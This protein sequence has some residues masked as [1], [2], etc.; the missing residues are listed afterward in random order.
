MNKIYGI[1]AIFA[2]AG[3]LIPTSAMQIEAASD[4]DY[5]LT[6]AEKGKKYIK[7]K[8]NEMQNSNIQDWKNQKAVLEIYD[9]SSNEIE[10]LEEAIENGDVKPA[11]KLF[12]SSMS[13]IK[14]ISL[15]LNQIAENKAQD[16]ALPDYS[17]ILKRFEI[18]T[19][20]LKQMSGKLVAN[21]DFSEL[22]NLILLG[23]E[24]VKNDKNVQTKQVI[25]QIALKG[26]EINKHLVSINHVNKIIKAQALAER[27]V[28][29]INSLIV[30]AKTSGLLDI[31]SQLE[32][33]KIHLA[34][35]NSTSQI[36]KNIK[37]IITINNNIKETQQKLRQANFDVDEIKLSQTQKFTGK[38]NQLET[39][40]KFLHSESIGSN[41]ALYYT[42][43]ALSIISDIRNN[44]DD[45]EGKIMS[46]IKLI[47]ELL[48][49][50]E[51]IVQ[52]ST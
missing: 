48:S 19:Q 18:N 34:S 21:I 35:S 22:D 24:N 17:Q 20:K 40:A 44:L 38:L 11:R 31:A 50:S 41:A 39:K 25:D 45:S 37:I 52:E 8:I 49:K 43:K 9:K 7:T 10:Q 29:K 4:L 33:T 46:K 2:F 47:E 13:K 51:K 14:Q 1:I 6:I 28:D 3:L 36:T 27:Y 5:M 42:E 12:V 26:L 23:K 32:N 15:M 16:D 30:Q